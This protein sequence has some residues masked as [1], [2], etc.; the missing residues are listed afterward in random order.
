ML[1]KRTGRMKVQVAVLLAMGLVGIAAWKSKTLQH[2]EFME[3][4]D[5]E[6]LDGPDSEFCQGD[7][8]VF[9]PEL[10]DIGC[11]YIP[12]CHQYRKRIT[13]E[14]R[15]PEIKYPQAEKN[16]NYV[17]IMADPDAPSRSEPKFRFWRHWLVID[18]KGSD[19]RAGRLKGHVLTDYVRPTPPSRSGYH[20]YQFRLYEQPAY[21]AI[22][23]SPEEAASLGSWPLERFVEQFRLGSPVASTQFLTQHHND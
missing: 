15:N 10:G 9:Y 1:E 6:K 14:W 22:S 17:L 2:S 16:K 13:K 19:L 20:R 18:I 4:C 23:L 5:F 3:T 12:K 21:E 7:L 11:T 8:Q